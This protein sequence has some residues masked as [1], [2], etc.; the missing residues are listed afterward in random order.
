MIEVNAPTTPVTI[1]IPLDSAVP[2]PIGCSIDVFQKGAAQVTIGKTDGSIVVY[3]TPGMKFRAQY[4]LATLT[5]RD[6]NTWIVS[7]DLT[8]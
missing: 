8:A 7:G 3:N 2:F 4:S 5:K 6:T 1:S